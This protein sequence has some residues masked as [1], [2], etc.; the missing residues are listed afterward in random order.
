[1]SEAVTDLPYRHSLHVR[2]LSRDH[3]VGR[4]LTSSLRTTTTSLSRSSSLSRPSRSVSSGGCSLRGVS[5]TMLRIPTL[6]VESRSTTGEM[7]VRTHVARSQLAS[8]FFPSLL[9]FY[10]LP[11]FYRRL[12]LDMVDLLGVR[13]LRQFSR[14]TQESQTSSCPVAARVSPSPLSLPPPTFPLSSVKHIAF[15]RLWRRGT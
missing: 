3:G 4:E 14:S 6:R 9:P 15:S 7:D 11:S 2:I 1:M 13:L 5:P 8:S 12:R 10:F